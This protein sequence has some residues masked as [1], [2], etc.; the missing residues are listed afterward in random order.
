M[1]YEVMEMLKYRKL[2]KPRML[3][4]S[5]ESEIDEEDW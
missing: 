5:N 1:K 4:L 2:E 3:N